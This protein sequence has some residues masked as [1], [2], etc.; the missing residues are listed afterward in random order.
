MLHSG[1]G[2]VSKIT[3]L[4]QVVLFADFHVKYENLKDD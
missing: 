3:P 2:T 1:T 4:F